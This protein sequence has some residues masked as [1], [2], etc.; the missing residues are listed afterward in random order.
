MSTTTTTLRADGQVR[1]T[2]AWITIGYPGED[3]RLRFGYDATLT[4]DADA[5]RYGEAHQIE[6]QVGQ[7]SIQA[8]APAD[9]RLRAE[10]Y[11]VAVQLGEAILNLLSQGRTVTEAFQAVALYGYSELPISARPSI[12]W[13]LAGL[14]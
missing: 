6:V 11:M 2:Q 1:G 5:Y 14:V 9:A 3:G 13:N 12:E 7:S 4:V 8:T 10:V